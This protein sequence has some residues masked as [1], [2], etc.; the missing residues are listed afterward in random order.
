MWR[1]ADQHADACAVQGRLDHIPECGQLPL[2]PAAAGQHRVAP[3]EPPRLVIMFT[4]LQH[5][6]FTVVRELPPMRY[7]TSRP[8]TGKTAAGLA[9]FV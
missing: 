8:H 9:D 2:L 5:A 4:A 6:C 3:S 1:G 7:N